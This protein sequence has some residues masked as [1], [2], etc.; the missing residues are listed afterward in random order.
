MLILDEPTNHLDLHSR[1]QLEKTLMNYQGTLIIVSHDRYFTRKITDTQ[2]IFHD[3]Q[4]DKKQG[5]VQSKQRD[6]DLLTLETRRQEVLAKLSMLEGQGDEYEA[7]DD[8]F[9][10]LTE[11]IKRLKES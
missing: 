2:L 5:H 11:K 6:T 7:L 9:N 8:V 10:N 1:E 3:Q 4:I